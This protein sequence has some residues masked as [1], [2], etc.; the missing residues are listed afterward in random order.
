MFAQAINTSGQVA[1]LGKPSPDDRLIGR[2]HVRFGSKADAV[3]SRSHVRFTPESG[4][5]QTCR[6]VR[7][8]P[9]AS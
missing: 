6:Y 1:G 7:L 4:Q 9:I 8:V 5:I 2:A 3:S